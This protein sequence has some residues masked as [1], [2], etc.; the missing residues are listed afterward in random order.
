MMSWIDLVLPRQCLVCSD[1]TKGRFLCE[2]CAPLLDHAISYSTR[3]ILFQG[4]ALK[5]LYVFPYESQV[6]QK[7]VSY[8]KNYSDPMAFQYCAECLTALTKESKIELDSYTVTNVPRRRSAARVHGFDQAAD[9]AK[10]FAKQNGLVYSPLLARRGFSREQKSLTLEQRR[11]NVIN[12]FIV[13]SKPPVPFPERVI[14][15]DDI[16]TS[17]SSAAECARVLAC[18]GCRNIVGLFIAG[19][20]FSRKPSNV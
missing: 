15:I 2:T 5:A 17:G 14:L 13:H 6:V 7:L 11:K 10:A 19:A 4:G 12:K 20:D 18:H 1:I 3:T 9:L 8:C 16:L